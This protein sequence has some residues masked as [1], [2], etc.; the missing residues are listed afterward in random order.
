MKPPLEG[1]SVREMPNQQWREIGHH[2]LRTLITL[3]SCD[4]TENI[5]FCYTLFG[6]LN[7]FVAK[8]FTFSIK[9]VVTIDCNNKT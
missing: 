2:Q 3:I 9:I 5:T 1:Y 8:C 7:H 4:T 6:S